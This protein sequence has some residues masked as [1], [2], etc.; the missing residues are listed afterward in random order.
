MF[1]NEDESIRGYA[2]LS[3]GLSSDRLLTFDND[4]QNDLGE[5]ESTDIEF[6]TARTNSGSISVLTMFSFNR[7]NETYSPTAEISACIE[8][9]CLR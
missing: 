3:L 6:F 2:S 9:D 8:S 1:H 4:G 7:A 5:D